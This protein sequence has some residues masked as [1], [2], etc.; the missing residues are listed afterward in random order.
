MRYAIDPALATAAERRDPDSF[1]QARHHYLEQRV[2]TAIDPDAA[3]RKYRRCVIIGDPGAGKTT[4]LKYL[5]LALADGK[6]PDLTDLPIYI[7]LSAFVSSADRDI[8]DYAARRAEECYAFPQTEGRSYMDTMLRDGKTIL[9]L[10]ALDETVVGEQPTQAD[11]SYQKAWDA[12]MHLASRY[13]EACIVVTARKA[14]YQQHRQLTGFTV[15]EVMD[16]R[17]KDIRQFVDN[18][19]RC[20]QGGVSRTASANDLM[21]RLDRNPR[22]QALAANPLLLSLIV[23]VYEAQLDLPD[24]RAELYRECVEVLLAKWDA[25]RNIRRRRIFKPDQ[26]RQLLAEVA[27]HF[28]QQGRRYFPEQELLT[29]IAHFLPA[30]WAIRRRQPANTA[31]VQPH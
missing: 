19:F 23:L 7:A 28:H 24:R 13:P 14:G 31:R 30:L 10:D 1:F 4:L 15:V 3:I 29:E 5:T 8:L 2:G 22:I 9:L 11:A 26:K 27:W 18:W 21:T 12:I 20:T 17:Q 6:Y 25:K 16:F